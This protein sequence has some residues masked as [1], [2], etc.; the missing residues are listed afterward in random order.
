[1]RFIRIVGLDRYAG[2][3]R[4]SAGGGSA[5]PMAP[6]GVGAAWRRWWLCCSRRSWSWTADPQTRAPTPCP[7]SRPSPSRTRWA[8]PRPYIGRECRPR[9]RQRRESPPGEPRR[10]ERPRSTRRIGAYSPR[11]TRR[12][13]P[14]RPHPAEEPEGA[15]A[16]APVLTSPI[17]DRTAG[18]PRRAR[19]RPRPRN[20]PRRK[21][22]TAARRPLHLRDACSR[23]FFASEAEP[24]VRRLYPVEDESRAGTKRA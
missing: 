24:T 7:F 22:G 1:M 12:P 19:P 13:S 15:E 9:R 11:V 23:A 16:A 5:C 14:S 21:A 18:T 10:E 8:C 6:V 3:P 17:T 20:R 2:W 4:S